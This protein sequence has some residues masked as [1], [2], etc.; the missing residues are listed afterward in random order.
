MQPA[1]NFDFPMPKDM[2]MFLVRLCKAPPDCLRQR[3]RPEQ[4]FAE[5]TFCS[6]VLAD[7]RLP[8]P[9]G[10]PAF[11]P[12]PGQP[13]IKAAQQAIQYTVLN[14]S[15]KK[16]PDCLKIT[17]ILIHITPTFSKRFSNRC[18]ADLRAADNKAPN[19]ARR[20][21]RPQDTG[22]AASSPFRCQARIP[23]HR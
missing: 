12:K 17:G 14:P 7:V 22:A 18:A 21:A 19:R 15:P 13:V 20:Q 8:K 6:G 2:R 16:K 3:K 4:N 11:L 1:A 5:D 23:R 10:D 9:A